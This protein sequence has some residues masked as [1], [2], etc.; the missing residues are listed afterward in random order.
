MPEPFDL[1]PHKLSPYRD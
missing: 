1:I